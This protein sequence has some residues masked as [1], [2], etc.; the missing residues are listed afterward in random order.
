MHPV[1]LPYLPGYGILFQQPTSSYSKGHYKICSR[2]HVTLLPQPSF[3][4]DLS[5]IDHAGDMIDSPPI[6]LPQPHDN[7]VDFCHRIQEDVSKNHG[8]QNI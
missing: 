3:Y 5:P 7:L 8:M 2:K 6:H 1:A 4:A